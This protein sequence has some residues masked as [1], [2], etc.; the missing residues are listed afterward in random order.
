MTE[1]VVSRKYGQFF[2]CVCAR[3]TVLSFDDRIVDNTVSVFSMVPRRWTHSDITGDFSP[4]CRAHSA[5][6]I[7]QK[8]VIIGGRENSAHAV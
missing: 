3:Q 2:G 5:T 1:S 7:A 4:P 8:V 6:L